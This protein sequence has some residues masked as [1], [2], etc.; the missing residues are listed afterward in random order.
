MVESAFLRTIPPDSDESDFLEPGRV[1]AHGVA[2]PST[3]TI[4]A[5]GF[6]SGGRYNG[7]TWYIETFLAVAPVLPPKILT[8]DG[9]FGF[10]T[11]GFGFNLSAASGQA[12]VVEASTNLA[13]WIPI[14]T[15]LMSGSG[16]FLFRDPESGLRPRRF[17][18][19]RLYA[20]VLPPPT[21]PSGSPLGF[22]GGRF[23][24][25]IAGVA[26][27]TVLVE[28]STNLQS[29]LPL[30]TNTLGAAMF[31]FSDSASSNA[32]SRF[33]RARLLP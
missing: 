9:T 25:N 14:H 11:N 21:I 16:L 15:N 4:R 29:W 12:V 6:V 28:T 2:V 32:P 13:T 19:A 8:S 22:Q 17:Y 31:Y 23:G 20:G 7:S 33:Y 26:G 3:C 5:R 27:Q 24:F 18:R 30:Q 10:R 1:A